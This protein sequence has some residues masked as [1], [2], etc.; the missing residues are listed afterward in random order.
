MLLYIFT[1][2]QMVPVNRIL[3]GTS[4]IKRNISFYIYSCFPFSTTPVPSSQHKQTK[5][6]HMVTCHMIFASICPPFNF[7]GPTQYYKLKPAVSERNWISADNFQS[8]SL[9][10]S[11]FWMSIRPI[12]GS[13]KGEFNLALV[14]YLSGCT[15]L[16]CQLNLG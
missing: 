3:C 2:V 13:E 8:V 12:E 10:S 15:K 11:L 9:F 6:K 1:S 7:F 14:I 4:G 5:N 16:P